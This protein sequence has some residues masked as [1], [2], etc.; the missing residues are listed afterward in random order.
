MSAEQAIETA[1]GSMDDE[2]LKELMSILK[3]QPMKILP[4]LRFARNNCVGQKK[5]VDPDT[6]SDFHDTYRKLWRLPKDFLKEFMKSLHPSLSG[7]SAEKLG[8]LEKTTDGSIRSLFFMATHTQ[9]D[10]MWPTLCTK[11]ASSEPHF[12]LCTRPEASA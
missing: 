11:K 6:E 10:T 8:R 5:E 4:T 3:E 9:P 7:L 2:G 12:R 1:L